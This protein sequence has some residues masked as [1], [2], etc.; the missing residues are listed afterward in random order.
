MPDT[1]KIAV[2]PHRMSV[3]STIPLS[4]CIIKEVT[5]MDEVVGHN[6]IAMENKPD[7]PCFI[8]AQRRMRSRTT[9]DT[10]LT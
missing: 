4:E 1:L 10:W 7:H 8:G 9:K 6:I 3:S 5:S 2:Y